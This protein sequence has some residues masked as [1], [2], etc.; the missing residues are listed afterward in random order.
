MQ[1]KKIIA[2]VGM[3]GSGKS[4][5]AAVIEQAGYVKVHFGA[6][7]IEEIRKRGLE[8]DE[9]NERAVREELR[10][11]HGMAAYAILSLPKIEDALKTSNVLIDGLYSW[12]EYKVIKK[13]F[14]DRL[15]VVALFST[16]KERKARMKIRKIR[17]LTED[18]VDSRDC[19]EI[20]NLEKGGPIAIADH[21]IVNDKTIEDLK[22]KVRRLL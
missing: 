3:C 1:Q 14:G 5:A 11:I 20:E 21:T 6:I 8:V 16:A 22:E 19:S 12:S 10:K 9:K 18:E 17:P 15:L 2:L 4:E 7:T 13:K